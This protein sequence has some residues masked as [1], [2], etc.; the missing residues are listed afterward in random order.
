MTQEEKARAYDGVLEQAKKE[1]NTCGSMDCDAARQI[2]RFFPQLCES[3]DERIRKEILDYIKVN[4][5]WANKEELEQRKRFVAY[6]EKQK[7]QK[8]AEWSEEDEYIINT[9]IHH[10]ELI[11]PTSSYFDKVPKERFLAWLKSRCS[12]WKPSEEQMGAIRTAID[13]LRGQ[14]Y[15]GKELYPGTSHVLTMMLNYFQANNNDTKV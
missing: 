4:Y 7:E 11:N 10:Y 1:L 8:P 15:D 5:R 9:L 13:V 12:P 3:E 2:F 14:V 6:L